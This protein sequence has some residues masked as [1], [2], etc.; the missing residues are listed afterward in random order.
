MRRIFITLTTILTLAATANAQEYDR[1]KITAAFQNLNVANQNLP[2]GNLSVDYKLGGYGK[3]RLGAVAD[4]AYQYDTNKNLDRYQF[5]G[6]PQVSYTLGDD[7]LSVFGR[8]LF[9][10]TRFDNRRTGLD[11]T[12]VTVSF[13]GGMD[14]HFGHFFVRPVQFDLQ[15]IDERPV[16]YTRLAAGGGFKF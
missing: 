2:G 13:G 9:G 1:V 11:F 10:A 3:W 7:K 5:L 14:V 12:R 16:R 4:G 15:Y 6:G 8:G